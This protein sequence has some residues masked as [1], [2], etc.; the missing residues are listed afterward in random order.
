MSYNIRSRNRQDQL[1]KEVWL[2]IFSYLKADP[3]VFDWQMFHY[4]KPTNYNFSD[5]KN[6]SL[7]SKLFHELSRKL[8]WRLP[9]LKQHVTLEDLKVFVKMKVPI[10]EMKLKHL[11]FA[12]KEGDVGVREVVDYISKNMNLDAFYMDHFCG[13]IGETDSL[14]DITL[15]SFQYFLQKLPIRHIDIGCFAFNPATQE[16]HEYL[17]GLGKSC[18]EISLCRYERKELKAETKKKMIRFI[19]TNFPE[20]FERTLEEQRIRREKIAIGIK[21]GLHRK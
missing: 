11:K 12:R 8:I 17:L 14:I 16:F 1:P 15:E 5:L 19:A 20:C 9:R 3:T 4:D 2:H 6:V 21:K 7:V 13:Y 18:P 10:R